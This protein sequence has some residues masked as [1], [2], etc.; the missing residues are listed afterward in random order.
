MRDLAV[1]QSPWAILIIRVRNIARG[2]KNTAPADAVRIAEKKPQGEISA[3]PTLSSSPLY[4]RAQNTCQ[5]CKRRVVLHHQGG[6]RRAH[7]L[8]IT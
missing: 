4:E 8:L 6:A 2:M 7:A 5:G 1:C 3:L